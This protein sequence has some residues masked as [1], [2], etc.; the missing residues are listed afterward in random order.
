[1]REWGREKDNLAAL[2]TGAGRTDTVAFC[3][4]R[5]KDFPSSLALNGTRHAHN[6]QEYELLT[7]GISSS[8]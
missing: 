3:R 4:K 5:Y 7:S 6:I 2:R 8:V 1:M